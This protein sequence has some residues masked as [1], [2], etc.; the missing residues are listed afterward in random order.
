MLEKVQILAGVYINGYWQLPKH[1]KGK[2][3]KT[4]WNSV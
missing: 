4:Q 1:C 3:K 2:E